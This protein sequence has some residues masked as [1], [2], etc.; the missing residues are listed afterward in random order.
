MHRI[1]FVCHGNICRST[2]A[3]FVMRYLVDQAGRTDDFVIDSAATSREEL[4]NDVHYGTRTKL[5][6]EGIP[7]GHH[8]ARQVGREELADWDLIVAMDQENLYGLRRLLGP[9][10]LESGQVRLLLDWSDRPRDIADPWY[11]GNFDQTF[12]DVMEGCQALLAALD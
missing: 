6:R 8:R 3:E 12:D 1:L 11:T 10:P 5:E 4:G 7:C 2:M 9:E